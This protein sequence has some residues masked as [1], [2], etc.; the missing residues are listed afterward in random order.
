MLRLRFAVL[1]AV[2]TM[3]IGLLQLEPS[4]AQTRVPTQPIDPFGLQTTL[5]GKTIVYLTGQA[6][7]ETAF[8]TLVEA[9]KTVYAFVDKEKLEPAG[10][11]FTI[12]TGTDD[13]GFE[14]Q[15][16]VPVVTP[17]NAKPPRDLAVGQSPDGAV[18]KFVHRGSYDSMTLT[19][20]AIANFFDE[21]MLE[22]KDW[23]IEEYLTDITKTPDDKLLINVFVGT[24]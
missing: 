4:I 15:A 16:A 17:P 2:A 24:K 21:K 14:F 18:Y 3:A 19:Y 6:K 13:N 7:W 11:A 22:A 5:P 12:Y 23:F 8:E 20:E 1:V 9:Y 10:P